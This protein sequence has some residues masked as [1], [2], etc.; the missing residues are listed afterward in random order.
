MEACSSQ[1]LTAERGRPLNVVF[2]M[3]DT[4]RYDHVGANGNDWVH[5]PVLDQFARESVIFDRS[6]IASF[7]TIPTRHD[8]MKGRFGNPLHEWRPLEWAALTLPEVLRQNDVVTMLIN[9]TPHMIN[10]GYGFD[11]PFH[12]WE[13]IRGNE[14]DRFRTSWFADWKLE[15]RE[16]FNI[17]SRMALYHRQE[18]ERVMEDEYCAPRVMK[19]AA[20]WLE[21]NAG[22]DGF[23]LWVDSFD[24]HEPW[25]PP[26][27]YVDLYDPD[28]D[29]ISVFWPRYG[30]SSEI[31]TPAEEDHVAKLFAAECSMC[32]T[33][34][35]RVFEKIDNL[36]LRHNTIVIIMSDHGHYLGE[37]DRLGKGGA[38]YEEVSRQILMIRH[39]DG[40][41]AGKRIQ[42]LVQSPDLPVTIM[43]MLGIAPPDPMDV[44]GQSLLPLMT[45]E[46]RSLRPVAI[47]GGYPHPVPWE[48]V[49]SMGALFD[50]HGWTSLTATGRD[51]ALIDFPERERWELFNR[52]ED[53]GMTVNRLKQHPEQA[54]KLHKEVLRFLRRNKAPR[55]MQ[56][57][58]RDGPDAIET[59]SPTDYMRLIRQRGM[60]AGAP[61]DGNVL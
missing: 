61:L 8:L 57:L 1:A 33:H 35:G 27:S 42:A 3:N 32:D 38:L 23:F 47:S 37:H 15:G 13:M 41:A 48:G 34:I 54:E 31:L 52:A 50:D 30:R 22:H 2:I 49:G 26:Q 36:G 55:W 11:R 4:W 60:P 7:A 17:D 25:D 44:Q 53:P 28:Y 45:G 10:L 6:Y 19:A 20:D 12:A 5:T 59:P 14:V 39:P 9:D 21:R 24:P 58:W 16:K 43:D 56:R 40:I 18:M 29:G 51:W 46:K